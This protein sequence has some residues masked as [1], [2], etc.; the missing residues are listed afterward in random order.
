M[1]VSVQETAVGRPG[2]PL[3]ANAL[4]VLEARY[5]RRDERRCVGETPDQLFARVADAVAG[6]ESLFDNQAEVPRWRDEFHRL[7]ASLEFLPNSPALM[8]AGT[9][10]GQLSA[11]FV[12]PVPDTMEGIFDAVKLM[13]LVQRTG[14][15]TGFSFSRLR[16]KGD[17]VSSTGG[18]SSGPVSFM[19]IFDCATENIKQGGRRRGANMGVLRADHPDILEFIDAKRDGRTLQNFNLSVGVTDAFMEAVEQDG[20]FALVH[21]GSGQAVDTLP[22]RRIL[23]AIV[24][25]AWQTGDPGLLF[26]DA[27]NRANPTPQLGEIETT[28]PCGEVPLLPYESCNLGSVNL[29]RMLRE[30]KSLG[31]RTAMSARTGTDELA[32]KAV[33]APMEVDWEKLAATVR[34][35]VRFLDN[36]IEANRYPAPEI[37]DLSRA[38]RKLGLGVMGFAEMLIRLGISYDSPEA[39]EFAGRLMKFIADEAGRASTALA[40]ARGVFAH[41]RGSVWEQRGRRVRNATLTAIAP[42]G[43]IGILA[44]TTPGIEPLFAL[45]YRRV[46]VLDGQTLWELNPLVRAW[47]EQR[48]LDAQGMMQHVQK[49][50]HWSG[51]PGVPEEARRLFV[52]ALEIPPEQHLQIQ[53]AFQ[54]HTDNSVSKTINLPRE[55]TR[56]DIA[57]A[58]ARAWELGLK[59]VTVYRYGSQASQVLELGAEETAAS[60]EHGM[61]CDPQ[62]CRL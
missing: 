38:N 19:R 45:A 27:I 1:N 59:G 4:R 9:P 3:S 50:G 14:G 53:A 32:D 54:R 57:H 12:L 51:L 18:E 61:R 25:A 17:L 8:N 21:P 60:C 40:E 62:E 43:T 7:L 44:G 31:A 28:N 36:V 39:A 48:G 15:G 13:A 35:A 46:N 22:A 16:P 55:A 30:S 5:L 56:H 47:L 23:D 41:W 11:C 6:A 29:A 49:H 52:T 34:I 2:A 33:R 26:L 42:T 58:Y 24:E 10:L 37:A 20:P